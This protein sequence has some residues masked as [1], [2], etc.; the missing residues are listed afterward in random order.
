MKRVSGSL[1]IFIAIL[2]AIL[3]LSA[4]N[5]FLNTLAS[6]GDSS[7]AIPKLLQT[8]AYCGFCIG[9][10]NNGIKNSR[11]ERQRKNRNMEE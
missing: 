6:G 4:L 5:L 8:L 9:F 11:S 1:L 2:L 10:M 7:A 3:T